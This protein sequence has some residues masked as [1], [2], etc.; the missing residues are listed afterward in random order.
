MKKHLNRV[1]VDLCIPIVERRP[2]TATDIKNDIFIAD[3]HNSEDLYEF[4]LDLM[5]MN[6][7]D[8]IDEL[9]SADTLENKINYLLSFY[10]DSSDCSPNILY[11]CV[12]GKQ[13]DENVVKYDSFDD[14]DFDSIDSQT[15]VDILLDE[16]WR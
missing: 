4:V 1:A 13:L 9:G 15:L 12:D 3:F 14:L 7:K 10:T 2:T 5:N 8:I 11:C 6:D 16:G